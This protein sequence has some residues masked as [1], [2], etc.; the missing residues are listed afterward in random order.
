MIKTPGYELI[1]SGNERKLER[2]GDKV[3]TRPSSLCVWKPRLPQKSWDASDATFIPGKGWKYSDAPFDQWEAE[4]SNVRLELRTMS[5]GQIG[6]F[7]EHALYLP[8]LKKDVAQLA[9]QSTQ[10]LK[11]LNLFAYTG[12]ATLSLAKE[13]SIKITH[14]DLSKK[15]MQ[16]AAHNATINHTPSAA[17]RW[18]TD[19]ALQFMAREHR[20]SNLYDVVIIDPPSFSR[21]SKE[22]TWTLE[23]K[24]PEITER[25]LNVLAPNHGVVYFTNHSTNSTVDLVR[26]LALDRFGDE[27]VEVTTQPLHLQESSSARL[28]P[29]GS[30]I[31]FRISNTEKF[32]G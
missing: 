27:S 29:A 32:L 6:I 30:L 7:P 17:V 24:L 28:M 4:I 15:A 9:Q 16:W 1:D 25:I 11:I 23:E 5:N 8:Q 14:V 19:D 26:N 3:I 2:F 12:M 22:N 18:I 13:N 31:R 10:S 20:K 21:I